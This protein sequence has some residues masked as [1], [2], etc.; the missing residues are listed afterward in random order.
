MPGMCLLPFWHRLWCHL[1]AMGRAEPRD[2]AFN[3][4]TA[5]L[6]RIFITVLLWVSREGTSPASS[7]SFTLYQD[8]IV[9]LPLTSAG[10]SCSK[11]SMEHS[12]FLLFPSNLIYVC[13]LVQFPEPDSDAC[14]GTVKFLLFSDMSSQH[15]LDLLLCLHS[16]LHFLPLPLSLTPNKECSFLH[17][18]MFP[19]QKLTYEVRRACMQD[20]PLT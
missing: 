3:Y 15:K 7:H 13:V 19:A 2:V 12:T 6:A 11:P 9:I 20:Y 18:W 10:S 8:S 16:H 5:G 17:N 4:S 1:G 14:R